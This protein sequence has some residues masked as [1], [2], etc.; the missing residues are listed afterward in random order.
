MLPL[1]DISR[2]EAAFWDQCRRAATSGNLP[3]REDTGVQMSDRANFFPS[4]KIAKFSASDTY[5]ALRLL[6]AGG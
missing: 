4:G 6:T 5:S 2:F 3:E 1:G